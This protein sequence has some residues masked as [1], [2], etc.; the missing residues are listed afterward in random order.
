MQNTRKGGVRMNSKRSKVKNRLFYKFQISAISPLSISSGNSNET[1]HDVLVT[2]NGQPIITGSSIAGSVYSFLET[3]GTEYEIL[4]AFFGMSQGENNRMSRIYISDIVLDGAY[5]SA[6]DGI[7]LNEFKTTAETAKYDYQ[8]VEPGASGDLFIE[9]VLYDNDPVTA[10]DAENLTNKIIAGINNGV[11]R[12]GYKKQRGMGILKISE[13]YGIKRFDYSDIDYSEYFDFL[14][15][16]CYD[17]EIYKNDISFDIDVLTLTLDL[18]QKGGVSIRTYS[19][20]PNAPDFS[21]IKLRNNN[22]AIIPGSSWNGAIRTRAIDIL[23]NSLH[24]DE[25]TI[26]ELKNIWG[27]IGEKEFVLSQV[28][29]RESII[30]PNESESGFINMTRNKINRFD[31][32][33]VD[34]ALYSESSFFGGTTSLNVSIKDISKNGWVAG[35][36]L[37]TLADIANGLLAVGGQTAV[38]RGIFN[39]KLNLTS[40]E[41]SRY[42]SALYNKLKGV[43][44]NV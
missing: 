11:I 42:I 17:T 13:K 16:G 27:E 19:A 38:G 35:L 8:I 1:D 34:H 9:Y 18:Q 20:I 2:E 25:Q 26:T 43:D 15:K 29:I 28:E 6:R 31:N 24:A 37:L 3:I 12:L 22:Q 10:K 39:G 14:E 44:Q 30:I 5:V 33:T 21:Q 40:T 36:I 7:R 41:N 23:S 32:S 4:E